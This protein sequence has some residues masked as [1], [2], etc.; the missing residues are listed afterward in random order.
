MKNGNVTLA[1]NVANTEGTNVAFLT[2]EGYVAKNSLEADK[3]DFMLNVQSEVEFTLEERERIEKLSD[4]RLKTKLCALKK[5]EEFYQSSIV[6]FTQ[7][8]KVV[9]TNHY[10][11]LGAAYL[12]ACGYQTEAGVPVIYRGT[13]TVEDLAEKSNI[14]KIKVSADSPYEFGYMIDITDGSVYQKDIFTTNKLIAFTKEMVLANSGIG[15]L[16]VLWEDGKDGVSYTD[17]RYGEQERNVMDV[18]IPAN[19]DKTR[20]N[21][22]L[23]FIH[24]GAW[25]QGGKEEMTNNCK[26]F[27]KLGYITATMS[28]SYAMSTLKNGE[29]AT[30]Y[31]I[32]NEVKEVFTK[33]KEMSDEKGWN[34]TKCAL[35]GYSS[36]CHLAYLYAYGKGLAADAPIPVKFVSGMVGCLDFRSE[37]WKNV[38]MD[39]PMVAALGINDPKLNDKENPYSEEEYNALM[40]SI[41]P[42]SFAKKGN[43]VPSIIAY[44]ELDETLIDYIFA[45]V[46]EKTLNEFGIRNKCFSLP[47][48]GH[49]T[50]NNP[51][52]VIAYNAEIQ[53][54]LKDYFGY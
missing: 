43:A 42:L 29:K 6:S 13:Y 14:K 28:H 38:T 37:Y 15:F 16:P 4:E 10:T 17:V 26:R 46:L 8:G 52:Y 39:G 21:G 12:S 35:S 11:K 1:E 7:K 18:Y 45:P 32:D 5:A 2:A 41:S 23:L 44:A 22:V 20:E 3:A 48:S 54:Y 53:N 36:G 19:L 30:F 34:I 40:D 33:L 27:A 51:E 49:I 24:G 31:T 47:N 9:I 25:T 50:G